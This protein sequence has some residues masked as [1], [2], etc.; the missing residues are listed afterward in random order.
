[1]R[2][3]K[4]AGQTIR[5]HTALLWLA[6]L[7]TAAC[8]VGP[9]TT[10]GVSRDL[11]RYRRQTIS[12]VR[13]EL[14]FSVPSSVDEPVTGAAT[15]RFLLSDAGHALVF[16]F[17]G[18][19]EAVASVTVDD[20]EVP[21]TV[22]DQHIIISPDG[23]HEGEIAVALEFVAGDGALNRHDDFLY[24]L[25]VPDRARSA[26]PAFDQPDLKG[27]YQLN[28]DVPEDW[29]AVSNAEILEQRL[30]RGRKYVRFTETEPI[31]TY[32][33]AF[34]AG[35]FQL[36][37][38]Q[39]DGR[40]LRLYHR[41]TDTDKVAR[42]LDAIF[43]LHA[44]ALSWLEAYTDIS[45]P[46]GK[47][48]FVAIPSFQYGGM[49]HPGSIL[50]RSGSLFLDESATQSQYLGRASLIA[51]ETAHMW[52]GDLVTM[53]WFD[54]V[55]MKEVFASFMAS[56]IVNPSFPEIDHDLRFFLAHH[57]AAYGVD[58][59]AGANPIRQELDNLNEAGTLYG[60]IIYQKA[61]I[62]MKHLE[63]LTGEDV[64]R[65]GLRSYLEEYAFGNATWLDLVAILD[66][67]T[68][69]DLT[70]WSRVWVEEP[71]R[72]EVTTD[73]Q[74]EGHAIQ[75]LRLSQSDPMDRG[76]RWTQQLHVTLGYPDGVRT[77][78]VLLSKSSADVP[79]AVG[80]PMPTFVLAGGDGL[81]YG[82]FPLDRESQD[83]LVRH[84]TE[85]D[86]GVVRSVAWMSLW[87]SVLYHQLAPET[88]IDAV[89]EAFPR[90]QDEQ[91]AQRMLG[92]VT[93]AFWR[94]V[95][96]P[97]QVRLAPRVERLLW[98][99]LERAEGT[100]RKAAF[101]NAYVSVAI[102]PGGIRR[103]E[104]VWRQRVT[105]EGLP[106]AEDDYSSLAQALA[107]REVSNAQEIL[108][109]Q[110]ER[111]GN[112]DRRARFAF[113]MPALSADEAVRDSVFESLKDADNRER[114]PWVLSV[115][116]FLHHP[117]RSASAEQYILPSL[118]LVEEIQVTGDIFFPLRWLN[119]TLDGHRSASAA[120]TVREFL[121]G[122]PD[123]PRRLRGKILQAADELFRAA[124]VNWE[125]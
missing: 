40:P 121:A 36:V 30:E 17:T 78:P 26:F 15:V 116:S 38:A 55:W 107:V 49:E 113:V 25:F 28:L 20:Q 12:D 110:L 69:H 105:V 22:T 41:E 85:I 16:D 27:R 72:P 6:A 45:Y 109:A 101:F 106:L 82:F 73:L 76:L 51:H 124:D 37:T 83:Y 98:S 112:P 81:G 117:L 96:P 29:E 46:F 7:L 79:E 11:A 115:V 88:F 108:N 4:L 80:L 75:R 44:S 94:F 34:V 50:Y 21:Y 35:R 111:I 24:T 93:S 2:E 13:Y 54:D 39:R 10:P 120:D 19:A 90:E 125:Q 52:F 63:G 99:E 91:N 66:G 97:E 58:R 9:D 53:E 48:D 18:L 95:D 62:V 70:A 64:L 77:V 71:G 14:T 47:F 119:A 87:E 84:A 114:E 56:K 67:L 43:D 104:D 8:R 61:P 59:T 32:L 123:Y 86:D 74:A 68:D 122:R 42:N 31:S 118:E 60:A 57:P 103:L 5:R 65:R 92:L 3:L 102:S 23:I 33:F 1:M 89:L 100:S